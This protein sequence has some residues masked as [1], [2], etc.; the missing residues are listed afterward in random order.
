MI[1]IR[2]PYIIDFIKHVDEL[3]SF[4]ENMRKSRKRILFDNLLWT[5]KHGEINRNYFQY[6]FD[7]KHDPVDQSEYLPFHLYNRLR[8]KANR[9]VKLVDG[10]LSY[11]S[12]LRD[13]Y[14]FCKFVTGL[15]LPTSD[16]VAIYEKGKIKWIESGN[17][18]DAESILKYGNVDFFCKGINGESGNSVLHIAIQN[19]QFLINGKKAS[20]QDL[21]E[22]VTS[23]SIFQKRI[24]QN[25]KINQLFSGSVNTIRI[26]TF[27]NGNNVTVFNAILK[28][29]APGEV[30][31]NWH[32]GGIVVGIDL[33]TGNLMPY[34]INPK[35]C[36]NRLIKH[37]SSEIAFEGFKIPFFLDALELV[38][39]LHGEL[40]G[41][42]T[43]GWD[44]AITENGPLVLEGNDNWD[45]RMFQA[46]YGGCKK[47]LLELFNE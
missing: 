35:K 1:V 47:R 19:E 30:L 13:K 45:F 34:G 42:V 20:I 39:K 32:F 16:V 14:V 46:Y 41:I 4:P 36:A 21:K 31:D 5:I 28:L 18:D 10:Y 15:S 7:R 24:I 8:K 12:I 37:P 33:N 17:I 11:I 44:I 2:I 26:G 23:K 40:Y 9:G 43:I 38:K 29:G 27:N 3:S 25:K 22:R 6:L